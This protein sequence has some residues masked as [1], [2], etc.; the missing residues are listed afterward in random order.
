MKRTLWTWIFICA[1]FITNLAAAQTPENKTAKIPPAPT[2]GFVPRFLIGLE[3]NSWFEKLTISRESPNVT[4]ESHAEYYGFG[5]NLEQNFYTP[6]W[7]WG[8]GAGYSMGTAV[9]GDK[10]GSLQYFEA[11]V[12]WWAA[13]VI[14]RIFFRWNP[15]TDFGIDLLAQYKHSKWPDESGAVTVKS[16]TELVGGGFLDLRIRFNVKLEMIQSFGMLYKDESI[17][18]RLGLAYRL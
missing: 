1:T 16:G 4:Q 5:L 15:Q 17:Y 14:P 2:S 10:A 9:G 18:W 7:G 11:R 8:I 12:P 13:H 3:Y 6:S